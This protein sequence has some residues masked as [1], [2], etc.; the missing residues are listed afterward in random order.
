MDNVLEGII[1]GKQKHHEDQ[2]PKGEVDT[3]V[4]EAYDKAMEE[5]HVDPK[6]VQTGEQ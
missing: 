5:N 2:K 1:A 3:L 6:L 4:Q